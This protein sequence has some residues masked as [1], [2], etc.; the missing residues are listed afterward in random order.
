MDIGCGRNR[1]LLEYRALGG[2]GY[3][4][5]VYR[6][7]PLDVQADGSSLPFRDAVFDTVS[8]VA[9]LNHIPDRE[10]CME[11]VARVL[12][13]GGRVVLTMISPLVGRLAHALSWWDPYT[14]SREFEEG[15]KHGLR[16]A[17][18]RRVAEH[19]GLRYVGRER[20]VA[21][22]NTLYVFDRPTSGR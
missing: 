1:L 13:P 6:W 16:E 10:R 17:E 3:G 18:L 4:C 22:M 11:E 8:L 9:C 21:R 19:P 20:F 5:D 15:E 7:G 12:R 2:R 14:H